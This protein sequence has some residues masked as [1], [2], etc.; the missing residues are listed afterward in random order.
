MGL[1]V[2]FFCL[3]ILYVGFSALASLKVPYA[4]FERDTSSTV[5]RKQQ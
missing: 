2:S 3:T 4:A 1:L 5:Q